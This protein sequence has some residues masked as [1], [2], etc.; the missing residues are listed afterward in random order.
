MIYPYQRTSSEIKQQIEDILSLFDD[1]RF[2]P[3]LQHRL[4]AMLEQT[5]TTGEAKT[6]QENLARNFNELA[7]SSSFTEGIL[8]L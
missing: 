4:F 6:W 7:T 8:S 3:A 2:M 1:H 5:T